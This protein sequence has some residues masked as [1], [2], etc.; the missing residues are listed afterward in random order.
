MG[1]KAREMEKIP[2]NDSLGSQF[3]YQVDL[4]IDDEVKRVEFESGFA[5]ELNE[6]GDRCKAHKI[7]YEMLKVHSSIITSGTKYACIYD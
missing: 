5:F 4:L 1:K 3:K 7:N 6:N 2:T